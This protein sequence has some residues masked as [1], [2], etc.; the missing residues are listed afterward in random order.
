MNFPALST[1]RD[2]DFA[3]LMGGMDKNKEKT[4]GYVFS[5]G[6]E[7]RAAPTS[8][9]G[10]QTFVVPF[11]LRMGTGVT[12]RLGHLPARPALCTPGA[13]AERTRR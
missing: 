6:A 10:T 1:N 4:D 8:G 13:D 12:H 2:P 9:Q 11:D 7:R 3:R 5:S